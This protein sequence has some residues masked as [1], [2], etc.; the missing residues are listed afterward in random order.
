MYASIYHNY[1]NIIIIIDI[2]FLLS[3]FLNIIIVLVCL[4]LVKK[5]AVLWEE[6]NYVQNF[7]III[8]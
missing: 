7:I 1:T 8:A 3:L 2:I 5:R 6:P 4:E